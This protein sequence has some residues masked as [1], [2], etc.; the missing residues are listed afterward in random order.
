MN[1][2]NQNRGHAKDCNC[3]SGGT[4]LEFIEGPGLTRAYLCGSCKRVSLNTALDLGGA[5]VRFVPI[6]DIL[7]IAD[8]LRHYDR[9]AEKVLIKTEREREAY[10]RERLSEDLG[11]QG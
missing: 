9:D 11:E 8:K 6:A 4:C 10:D 7:L 5:K 3:K 1:K 2:I